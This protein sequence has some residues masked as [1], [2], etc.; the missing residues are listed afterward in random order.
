VASV[1]GVPF[2]LYLANLWG[3]HTPFLFLA[4]VSFAVI[5]LVIFFV[6][7]MS[8]HLDYSGPRI[9]PFDS[10][11]HILAT[12]NQQLALLFMFCLILGQFT[13]IPFLS[14][15]FVANAGLREDQLPLI[16]LF[17]GLCSMVASPMTGRLADRFGKKQV[18]MVGV[19]LSILPIYFITTMSI[20]PAW[21]V[22][23]I[24]CLFFIMMSGRMV[25]AMAMISSTATAKYRGSFMSVSSAVQQLSA[26]L[27]SYLA[28]VIVV[29]G[30]DGRLM[31]YEV[32][33]YIAIGFS[34]IAMWVARHVR[35]D[36]SHL[37][38]K[39]D[40]SPGSGAA[41]GV[42]AIAEGDLSTQGLQEGKPRL[43]GLD[44]RAG[45][46]PG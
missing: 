42:G 43:V 45:E 38:P 21:F 41:S 10:I 1:L 19:A 25:P 17:G 2:S 40:M 13:I 23:S 36:E 30:A 15:S 14:P 18:F 28:G 3:W 39:V 44:S 22:L 4:A 26:A 5:T 37:A 29:K 24:S 27:A 20:Q 35:Q 6:P 46:K 34:F 16:Y 8:G 33:G 32:V 9:L 31:N 12:P 7:K 11:K